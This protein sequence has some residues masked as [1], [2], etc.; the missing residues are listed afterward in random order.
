MTDTQQVIDTVANMFAAVKMRD[1][2]AFKAVLHEDFL[3]HENG[4]RLN[5]DGIFELIV[6]A[7]D[8]GAEFDWN[9]IEPRVYVEGNLAC[10]AYRN[11]GSVTR[12]GDRQS[13]EWLESATLIKDGDE[14]KV[15]FMSSMRESQHS[16]AS[17]G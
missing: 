2:T 12:G 6:N 5:A 11:C 3:L 8:G 14:W 9:I 16:A 4:Q 10:L 15:A 7:Q 13:V 1:K 17:T